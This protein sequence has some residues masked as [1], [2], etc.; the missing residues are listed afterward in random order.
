MVY[1]SIE[2]MDL[3]VPYR[4]EYRFQVT[5]NTDFDRQIQIL[6]LTNTDMIIVMLTSLVMFTVFNET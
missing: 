3:S 6:H 4:R 5:W 1:V 2:Q